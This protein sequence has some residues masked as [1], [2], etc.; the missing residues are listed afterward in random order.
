[1]K[2]SFSSTSQ[3]TN[4]LNQTKCALDQKCSST[5]QDALTSVLLDITNLYP[6]ITPYLWQK[7]DQHQKASQD[8]PNL[9][10]NGKD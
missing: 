9:K 4:N 5:S 8:T 7:L 1:M 6:A 10:D 3:S 2:F